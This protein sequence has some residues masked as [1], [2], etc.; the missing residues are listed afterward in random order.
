VGTL[1]TKLSSE[2]QGVS[3]LFIAVLDI[4]GFELFA[5]NGLEQFCI[6]YANEK[7]NELFNQHLF[8]VRFLDLQGLKFLSE[9]LEYQRENIPW[10]NIDFIDT[11]GTQ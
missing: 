1:N 8:K 7:L 10:S 2:N 9:Q 3:D 6:N 4:Y 5:K 11:K